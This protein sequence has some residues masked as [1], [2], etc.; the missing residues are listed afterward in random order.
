MI[1]N[2]AEFSLPTSEDLSLCL[3]FE[4]ERY[5]YLKLRF[6]AKSPPFRGELFILMEDVVFL[7]LQTRQVG[8]IE[9]N[10]FLLLNK[11]FNMWYCG[12]CTYIM[13]LIN[14]NRISAESGS[15]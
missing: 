8:I 13:Y 9:R 1:K 6:L 4:V 11:H 10:F 14:F 12:Q 5:N 7:C 3:W 2:L 15:S